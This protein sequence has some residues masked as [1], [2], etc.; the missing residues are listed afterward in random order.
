MR[1]KK[2][3]L[4]LSLFLA[5]GAVVL[6][7]SFKDI[8]EEGKFYA[9]GNKTPDNLTF[10]E[11]RSV[12]RG[13]KQRW[14][15]GTKITLALM[16]S[17]TPLGAQITQKVFYMTDKELNKYFLA[18]VFQGKISPPVFFDSETELSNYV[19]QN[20]GAIGVIGT[21]IRNKGKIILID[22][23]TNF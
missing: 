5:A 19:S 4:L 22:G 13:E 23:K 12:L 16:K 6:L 10:S 9:L 1:T 7:S 8:T 11:L 2:I 17:S 20:E 21:E 15:D 14:K 18:L 3:L